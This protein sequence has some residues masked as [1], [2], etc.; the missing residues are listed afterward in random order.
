VLSVIGEKD[1]QVAADRNNAAIGE[2]LEEGDNRQGTFMKL[3]GLNH[4]LQTAPTS[5]PA[6][7]QE[8]AKTMSLKA[9]EAI[10][11]WIA[12]QLPQAKTDK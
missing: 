1:M 4:L 9:M 7:Y 2:A 3:V 12:A 10:S 5:S 8:I 6:E 11:G